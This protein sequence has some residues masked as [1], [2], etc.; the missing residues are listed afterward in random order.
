[1]FW[2]AVGIVA[3]TGTL[4]IAR[5]QSL[6]TREP[7]FSPPARRVVLAMFPTLLLGG[8]VGL[9]M[10]E[11]SNDEA[12]QFLMV[13]FIWITLYGCALHEAGYVSFTKSLEGARPLTTYSMTA[14]GEKAFAD[15]I[16]LLDQIVWQSKG[17]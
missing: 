15:Y 16:D 9:G 12:R 6:K 14:R 2:L 8:S 13:P 11:L 3:M 10:L 4:V 7:V 1:R 5:R 17:R